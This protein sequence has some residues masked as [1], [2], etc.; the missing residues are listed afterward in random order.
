MPVR[1]AARFG[2]AAS[3]SGGSV[4]TIV[5]GVPCIA[6]K[7]PSSRRATASITQDTAD[8]TGATGPVPDTGASTDSTTP[9][10]AADCRGVGTITGGTTVVPVCSAGGAANTIA[11]GGAAGAAGSITITG[12]IPAVENTPGSSDR[13]G[14]GTDEAGPTVSATAVFSSFD[15]TT[16]GGRT[17][18]ARAARLGLVAGATST[19][20]ESPA[21]GEEVAEGFSATRAER[22]P[23]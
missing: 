15:V 20:S 4:A 13:L 9:D 7:L 6:R 3:S 23:R 10:S 12:E 2:T 8:S 5:A 21:C 18:E 19:R 14:A 17:A 11:A 1:V 22:P 16:S